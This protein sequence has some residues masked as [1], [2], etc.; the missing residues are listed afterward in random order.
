MVHIDIYSDTVCPWCYIVKRRLAKALE[1]WGRDPATVSW[2]T[3]QL[4]PEMPATG[5]DRQT[6]LSLKFGGEARASQIY[7]VIA[8]NG[9]REDIPF[10][11]DRIERTPN[12]IDSHRLTRFAERAGKQDDVVEA[13]FRAYFLDGLDIGD[14]DNLAGLAA[15]CGLDGPSVSAYLASDRDNADVQAEDR[16]ARRLGIDGVPCFIVNGRYALSGAQE[17]EAFA[18]IFELA[19]SEGPAVQADYRMA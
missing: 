10:A 13:L 14:R 9:R 15:S 11:F 6:Y 12:T 19:A 3:F 17:P 18:P 7:G 8:D 2:R 1:A 4:N 5:M 16:R